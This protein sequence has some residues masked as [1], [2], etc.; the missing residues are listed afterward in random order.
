MYSRFLAVALFALTA[1]PSLADETFNPTSAQRD[2]CLPDV[3]KYCKNVHPPK[4]ADQMT[5][6]TMYQACLNEHRDNSRPDHLS[7]KCLDL[8]TQ[9]GR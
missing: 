3:R 7:Q 8:F 2:A 5:V 9:Y 6:Q 4:G 1:A